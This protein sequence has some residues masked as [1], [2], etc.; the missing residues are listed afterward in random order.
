MKL[1]ASRR[2]DAKP[3]AQDPALLQELSEAKFTVEQLDRRRTEV[4]QAPSEVV[5][6]SNYPTPLSQEVHGEELH[7]QLRNG[8]LAFIPMDEFINRLRS[9]MEHQA[10]DNLKQ[11]SRYTETIGPIDGFSF[12]YT[13]VR[14]DLTPEEAR[15]HG[16]P[17]FYSVPKLAVV[18]PLSE[19]LGEPVEDALRE[20][21]EFRRILAQHADFRP[22]ITIWTYPD[23]FAAFRRIKEELH[24]LG[25]A[26]AGRPLQPDMPIGVSSEGSRSS[27][28]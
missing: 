18:I 19:T 16:G 7:F 8:R 21:S 20:S 14:R 3:I 26:T 25:F 4:E 27:A 15:R 23:G 2:P 1:E 28:E 12:R 24:R 22:V 5:Q 13:I 9:D 17:G 10:E 11:R 6:V